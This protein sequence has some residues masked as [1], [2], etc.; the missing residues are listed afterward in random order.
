MS[1]T[2]FWAGLRQSVGDA[3]LMRVLLVLFLAGSGMAWVSTL[4]PYAYVYFMGFAPG[5]K[6]LAHGATMVGMAAGCV[7]SARVARRFGKKAAVLLGGGVSLL[8]TGMLAALFL[9]GGVSPGTALALVLFVLFHAAFW[10]GNG[11]LLPT[12]VAMIADL[13]ALHQR[14]TG[15]NKDG[16]Y[17]ALYS[18]S[19]K[20]STA[21]ALL[22]SG[23]VLRLI[24]FG[25]GVALGAVAPEAVWRL[26]AA[27]FLA[28][29]LLTALA[30]AAL[31]P[32]KSAKSTRA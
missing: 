29:P 5:Q 17:A 23:G 12:G 15:V 26:G 20:V 7:L 14:C 30:L 9:T 10:L 22:G 4:Q 3:R 28:G 6:T 31:A 27:M 2:P 8:S 25:P 11:I 18:L 21:F 13:S 1:G 16:A 24:G 19:M 32:L